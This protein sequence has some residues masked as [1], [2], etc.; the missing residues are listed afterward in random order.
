MLTLFSVPVD[1][2]FFLG[3]FCTTSLASSMMAS[4]VP[5]PVTPGSNK[6]MI[7]GSVGEDTTIASTSYT[8]AH[9]AP[10]LYD[11]SPRGISTSD[12]KINGSLVTS[13]AIPGNQQVQQQIQGPVQGRTQN[14]IP[15][16]GG[17]NNGTGSN[18]A[19]VNNISN[20]SVEA[21]SP[22]VLSGSGTRGH[23]SGSV[24]NPT[25]GTI[26]LNIFECHM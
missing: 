23:P 21:V 12:K 18:V 26:L 2:T 1:H 17:S 5:K 16:S 11:H 9:G 14:L 25:T 20:A 10:T 22:E 7:S 6:G 8:Q 13:P 24:V 4:F 15:G 3:N 19:S